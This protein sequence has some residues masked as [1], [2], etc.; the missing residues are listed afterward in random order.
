MLVNYGHEPANWWIG[1]LPDLERACDWCGQG[2][3]SDGHLHSCLP[4]ASSGSESVNSKTVRIKKK[5][6]TSSDMKTRGKE[7]DGRGGG[8][9]E[10]WLF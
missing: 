10:A 8:A 9:L 5:E 6:E 1:K 3:S 7:E 2:P 4:S